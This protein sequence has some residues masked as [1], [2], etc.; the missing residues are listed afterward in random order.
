MHWHLKDR[1]A[2][3]A[4]VTTYFA[5]ETLE[6]MIATHYQTCGCGIWVIVE[7]DDLMCIVRAME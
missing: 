2:N 7:C 5:R 6:Q 3:S 4:G 1:E